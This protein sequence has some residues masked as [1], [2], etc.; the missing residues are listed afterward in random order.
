MNIITYC[1]TL[2]M[3]R[4]GG[5]LRHSIRS[6]NEW[7]NVRKYCVRYNAIA[8]RSCVLHSIAFILRADPACVNCITSVRWVIKLSSRRKGDIS[9]SSSACRIRNAVSPLPVYIGIRQQLDN[10]SD[11]SMHSQDTQTANILRPPDVIRNRIFRPQGTFV[12]L[13]RRII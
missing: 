9:Y 4:F 11:Q 10:W 1:N 2:H 8:Q 5:K 6:V 3:W 7:M 13:L 12:A